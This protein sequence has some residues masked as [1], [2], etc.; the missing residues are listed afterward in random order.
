MADNVFGVFKSLRDAGAAMQYLV[1]NKVR[2]PSLNLLG[3]AGGA[4]FVAHPTPG[5]NELLLEMSL[6]T[7]K[8]ADRHEITVTGVQT[9]EL[10]PLVGTGAFS[11]PLMSGKPA[12]GQILL[13]ELC[14]L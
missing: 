3:H 14:Q 13:R 4:H 9:P 12:R 11:S 2:E 8:E 5:R 6:L 10:G 1:R 7:V